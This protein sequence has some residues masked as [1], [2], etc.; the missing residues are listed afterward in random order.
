[1]LNRRA[2]LGILRWVRVQGATFTP[3]TEKGFPTRNDSVRTEYRYLELAARVG[4][5]LN[6]FAAPTY[7]DVAD[8]A[9]GAENLVSVHPEPT[10]TE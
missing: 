4:V 8:G 1:M 5:Y 2:T 9:N 6:L 7:V 10:C 3:A